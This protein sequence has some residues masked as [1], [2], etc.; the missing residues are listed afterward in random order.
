MADCIRRSSQYLSR[1]SQPSIRQPEVGTIHWTVWIVNIA[2]FYGNGSDNAIFW[3]WHI[4]T[5]L[6][7]S[8]FLSPRHI[9]RLSHPHSWHWELGSPAVNDEVRFVIKNYFWVNAETNCMCIK[10]QWH[11]SCNFSGADV[12]SYTYFWIIQH[13]ILVIAWC[14]WW[15]MAVRF[16]LLLQCVLLIC[17]CG[18]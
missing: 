10:I 13:I 7:P 12:P 9:W 8:P 6:I 18:A 16:V 5:P 2:I 14:Y 17:Y 3:K 15:S 4:S 1:L 11:I